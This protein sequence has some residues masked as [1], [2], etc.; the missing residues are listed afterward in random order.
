M[1]FEIQERKET[2]TAQNRPLIQ[3][4]RL[5]WLI[6]CAIASV[7]LFLW[8]EKEV[9]PEASIDLKLT[10]GQVTALGREWARKLSYTRPEPIE[11]TTFS[12]D[13]DAKMF[14]E[15]ELGGRRAN[16]L[17]KSTIPVW[18]W[19]TRLCKEY[20][21]EEFSVWIN[22]TGKLV[23]L[24][25][26]LPN[27]RELPS[28]THD[29]ALIKAEEF[30][31]KTAG[32][33]LDG[34]QLV[35]DEPTAQP[36]RK[37]YAFTWENK[38]TE[39]H[40]A[41]LR[42]YV[43][44]SGDLVTSF[45]NYLHVP[46]EWTRK[47]ETLR[48]YNELFQQIA[49]VFY[50]V[51]ALA[52]FFTMIWA[53]ASRNARWSFALKVAGAFAVGVL[54][55]YLNGLPDVIDD[56]GVTTQ[57]KAYLIEKLNSALLGSISIGTLVALFLL[58]SESVYRL[59]HPNKVAIENYF[60]LQSLKSS[61][62]GKGILV[63]IC[64]CGIL[65][66]WVVLYY[67]IGQRFGF[68]CPLDV[69]NYQVLS[70]L[71]PAYS[72]VCV[73]VEAAG[74]EE[75]LYRVL[76]LSLAYGLVSRAMKLI[77]RQNNSTLN[78]WIAN[79][80]QA[81]AW[82]FMHSNYP[83]QP[84]FARGLELT[85][86][87]LLFGW[88]MNAFGLLPCLVAH[89][90]LDAFLTSQPL[91]EAANVGVFMAGLSPLLP[92][93]LLAALCISR[94]RKEPAQTDELLMNRTLASKKPAAI[95]PHQVIEH[96]SY[97]SIKERTRWLLVAILLA[98]ISLGLLAE[99]APEIGQT[100]KVLISRN[101]AIE[102]GWNVMAK[103]GI[104]VEGWKSCAWL[105]QEIS[106]EE[107]QYLYEKLGLAKTLEKASATQPGY[108]WKIRFFKPLHHEEYEVVLDG[109]GKELSFD[110]TLPEEGS[111]ARLRE[112]DARTRAESYL[113]QVHPEYKPNLFENVSKTERK[114]RTDYTFSYKIPE[115]KVAEADSK[116]SV[117]VL[118]DTV[119]DFSQRW[120]LPD[121]WRFER[122]KRTTKDEVLSNVRQVCGAL[123]AL[124]ALW[125]GI[126]LLRVGYMPW[127]AAIVFGLCMAAFVIPE[128]LNSWPQLWIGY[129][130]TSPIANHY[131]DWAIGFL[132]E[133]MSRFG[134]MAF[135]AAV[136]L[137]C[138]R[139]L[140]PTLKLSTLARAVF[141]PADSSER[142][143]QKLL[144]L[145]GL[146]IAYSYIALNWCSGQIFGWLVDIWS[147]AAPQA[148]LAPVCSIANVWS[149]T[150]TF[151]SD[152]IYQ[153]TQRLLVVPIYIGLYAKYLRRF[154]NFLIF[155]VL[156][157]LIMSSDSRYW[158][159]YALTCASTIIENLILWVFIARVARNNPTAYF[160]MGF[161]GFAPRL[162][163]IV[164]HG[165]PLFSWDAIYACLILLM[166]VAYI[167]FLYL[168]GIE[169]AGPERAAIYR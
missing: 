131:A 98:S 144:W 96:F 75:L 93:P 57:F 97:R 41:H 89:Y 50:S 45:N 153:G 162:L 38:K 128:K 12:Y 117:S 61:E 85:C 87:G 86:S 146:I 135:F 158:Q 13:D 123:L 136:S 121:K 48:S 68:W 71:V 70:A 62:I 113:S 63:G 77:G 5:L 81:A 32:V 43:S 161:A 110:A 23:A 152:A 107:M 103:H 141:A 167:V 37:D 80:M 42:I 100:S 10:R 31:T 91:F 34:F 29:Q 160:L 125:W 156:Q 142:S 102:D 69:T 115:E 60:R 126:G 73:G 129:S 90:L 11:S 76:G 169:P 149:P 88:V 52:A 132:Q 53:I 163:A 79:L 59:N 82:G 127:R 159:N 33:S 1:S 51:L 143:Q 19:R 118:G 138:L 7:L 94:G 14:L 140:A 78:F 83:Q 124:A 95:A 2:S 18:Y 65:L 166:P 99:R 150:L 154:P 168:K 139:L 155:I 157:T 54:L 109:A 145:D 122:S 8:K 28:L 35:D 15:Y 114:N 16:E 108:V 64:L 101:Q 105:T 133:L 148:W 165:V 56:Y 36:H 92:F 9:F 25:H 67:L 17:M 22:P 47:F 120:D 111:G 72:A 134:Q 27:D 26:E 74:H 112:Q 20:E 84:A 147:P 137:M 30:V 151:L 66:G 3:D 39:F 104:A 58:A 106:S 4:R 44:I 49:Q 119:S 130:T 55:L 46:D 116:L 21:Q 164:E 6:V 24:N 40:G